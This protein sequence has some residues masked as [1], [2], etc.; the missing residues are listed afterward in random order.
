MRKKTLLGNSAAL[1][2]HPHLRKKGPCRHRC[3]RPKL[4]GEACHTL[5]IAPCGLTSEPA[6]TR[7]ETLQY[8]ARHDNT[9]SVT[10]RAAAHV[11]SILCGGT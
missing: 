3:L 2:I 10:L 5:L 8:K 6:G 9:G 1:H 4:L 11:I 7:C